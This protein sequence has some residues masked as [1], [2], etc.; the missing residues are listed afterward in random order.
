MTSSQTLYGGPFGFFGYLR[1]RY[2][3]LWK[4]RNIFD[5]IEGYILFWRGI[6]YYYE[7]KYIFMVEGNLVMHYSLYAS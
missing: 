4:K 5:L 6:Y 2:F 3:S 7:N 1:D